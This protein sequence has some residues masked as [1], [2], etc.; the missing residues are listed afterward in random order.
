MY[1]RSYKG[2]FQIFCWIPSKKQNPMTCLTDTWPPL[3]TKGAGSSLYGQ[4]TAIHYGHYNS[5]NEG[6]KGVGRR[7]F[8]WTV[9]ENDGTK[10]SDNLHIKGNS[11][12]QPF[13][14]S[15]TAKKLAC[16]H[17]HARPP[18]Q[19][20][21]LPAGWSGGI[22]AG[23]SLV[24]HTWHGQTTALCRPCFLPAQFKAQEAE[25]W[26]DID[27]CGKP[28]PEKK[29]PPTPCGWYMAWVMQRFS[30]YR[31]TCLYQRIRLISCAK[32][33]IVRLGKSSSTSPTASCS[34]SSLFSP[35]KQERNHAFR[36]GSFLVYPILCK[37]AEL[38]ITI[39]SPF[40]FCSYIVQY[41]KLRK[42]FNIL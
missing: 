11:Q 35:D 24:S 20:S 38:F 8:I 7:D 14:G 36:H 27:L 42:F 19:N 28:W 26:F 18:V 41:I 30:V 9:M 3:A 32:F 16:F 17:L 37:K 15:K 13:N 25:P 5:H 23:W 39:L 2:I 4:I 21:W 12:H 6:C 33:S 1:R 10:K 29:R 40:D 31:Q 34:L 22:Y